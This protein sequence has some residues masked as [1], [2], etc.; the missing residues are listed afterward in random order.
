MIKSWQIKVWR[1]DIELWRGHLWIY[2]GLKCL[3]PRNGM[4]EA[5]I[6]EW[7][8]GKIEDLLD[9]IKDKLGDD[10]YDGAIALL[11]E[12]ARNQ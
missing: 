7:L 1:L 5:E 8:E 12:V 11:Q 9:V 6:F 2:W 10:H 3:W 4:S